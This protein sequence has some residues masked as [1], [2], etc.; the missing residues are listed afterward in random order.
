MLQSKPET[1]T[2]DAFFHKQ[3]AMVANRQAALRPWS[4]EE[5]ERY[6]RMWARVQY[7]NFSVVSFLLPRHLR[8]DFFNVYAYC[9]WSDNLADEIHDPKESLRLLQEWQRELEACDQGQA[10]S[11]PILVALQSTREKHR[12]PLD[13]FVDLLSAFRQD[14]SVLRYETEDQ[15]LDYCRRSANPVGRILLGL[16]N[17][18]TPEAQSLSDQVCTG[19]QIANFCQDMARDAKIDRIYAPQTL[20]RRFGVAEVDILKAHPSG[21]LK[22]MLREWVACAQQYLM[23]GHRLINV[24]PRWLAMDVDLFVRGGLRI[25]HE[26]EKLDY[27]VWTSRPT[28]GKT[29]KA[30][31]LVSSLVRRFQLR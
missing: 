28:V 10:R 6:C 19:L 24:V 4:L 17:V 12:L 31:L 21:S 7:E 20:W 1:T 23:D 25:L 14:Q 29:A 5:A 9:R 3:R 30:W 16:A 13:S 2:G 11:H 26:I 8:Q 15:L 22:G 18:R 27:D